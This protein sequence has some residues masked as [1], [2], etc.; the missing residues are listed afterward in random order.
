MAPIG[1]EFEG[2]YADLPSEIV[3]P[4][5]SK[6]AKLGNVRLRVSC[7]EGIGNQGKV[8]LTDESIGLEFADGSGPGRYEIVGG[9]HFP[10]R[11]F[12]EHSFTMPR[13]AK[14]ETA[15]PSKSE[16]VPLYVKVKGER[17]AV[18]RYI[19]LDR[20]NRLIAGKG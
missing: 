7:E 11:G 4:G 20:V 18:L 10:V 2:S 16:D 19:S 1:V 6:E 15:F 5:Q 3:M 9:I 12:V 13:E 8:S 17:V 14:I